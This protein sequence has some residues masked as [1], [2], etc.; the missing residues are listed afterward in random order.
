MV[1]PLR[2][3]LPCFL[4]AALSA[5]GGDR[6]DAGS[7]AAAHIERPNV[8][9]IL[10]DG[11][12]ADHVGCYGYPR[13]TTPALDALAGRGRRYLD[14]ITPAPWSAPAMASLLAGRYP[15]SVDLT[16]LAA[17]LSGEVTLLPERARERGYSTAAVVSHGFVSARWS[18]DQ[19]FEKFVLV[20]SREPGQPGQPEGPARPTSSAVTDAALGLMNQLGQGPFLL[21]AHYA[22]PMPDWLEIQGFSFADPAYAGD[23]V[24]GTPHAELLRRLP[25]MDESDRARVV[26]HY[27]AELA[28]TDSQVG[29]LLA[30]LRARG[31]DADTLVVLTS[32]HGMELFDHGEL[33][34]AKTLYDELIHV[35]LVIAGP[36]VEP[37]EEPAAVSLIDLAPTLAA[38]MGLEPDPAVEG[39]AFAAVEASVERELFS[40]TDRA[41]S[42]RSLTSGRWKL[43]HD[44][45]RGTLQLYD[46]ATDPEEL[47]DLAPD[48]LGPV[49][50]LEASLRRWEQRDE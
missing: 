10:I 36:G 40:E 30:G 5:C 43:V 21:L 4:A 1:S 24:P 13:D 38:S 47:D 27:D 17:P 23:L 28:Y 50:E 34:D 22:D 12:R 46:L 33:G 18:L 2:P 31:R 45:Q 3:V 11:L 41:R 48:G 14:V 42:L 9:L 6:V 32:T 39:L 8:L 20:E 44:L 49:K 15:S 16:D 7:G 29:R 37:G 19:G 25:E 26:A 35:P